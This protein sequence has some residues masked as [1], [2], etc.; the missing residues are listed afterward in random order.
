MNAPL[1]GVGVG[2]SLTG[3]TLSLLSHSLPDRVLPGCDVGR[4]PN[5]NLGRVIIVGMGGSFGIPTRRTG[6]E[7]AIGFSLRSASLVAGRGVA[8][9][10][11]LSRSMAAFRAASAASRGTKADAAFRGPPWSSYLQDSQL[12]D[13]IS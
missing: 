9:A 11:A 6:A 1:L 3:A 4:L 8:C 5:P 10:I 13:F 7:A 12:W 2:F